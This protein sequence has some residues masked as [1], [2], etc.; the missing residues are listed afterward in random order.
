M[1]P[2]FAKTFMF[3][4]ISPKFILVLASFKKSLPEGTSIAK[5]SFP[6]SL[7][8]NFSAALALEI[9]IARTNNAE[10]T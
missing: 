6:K 7:V 4:V 8:T 5:S 9:N 2:W 1:S 3:M 10:K